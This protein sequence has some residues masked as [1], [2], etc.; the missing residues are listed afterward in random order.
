MKRLTALGAV[1][2]ISLVTIGQRAFE[3]NKEAIEPGTMK[4][5]LIPIADDQHQTQLPVT[6]FH[7]QHIGPVLG[8]TAGVHGYEYAPIMAGQELIRSID[9]QQLSGT[10]ILVQIAN[11]ESFLGRSPYVNPL[12]KKNLN[13]SFPGNAEGTVTERLADFITQQVI[14]RCN[15]FLD[16]HSGDAPEDLMP[17]SAYYQH[18]KFPTISHQAKLMAQSMGFDHIVVFKTT[19]KDYMKENQPSLYC[20]AQA[21]KMGIPSAD[22]ECGKLGLVEPD[23]IN[24]IVSAVQSLLKHLRMSD[25]VIE[26]N[27]DAL[28]IADRSYISSD[29]SGVFYPLKSSGDYITKGTKIGY[30]TDFF[31]RPLDEIYAPNDGIILYMLGT[32]PVNKGETLVTIGRVDQASE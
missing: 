12:D 1:M 14:P 26:L 28:L 6:V 17:Y 30:I 20:S 7:G 32:P 4:H 2:L 8:I 16:M 31:N 9:P 15:F 19:E 22:I 23:L 21:F 10:V 13:R 5:F 29:Q 27:T 3:F 11:L 25:G 24:K 18:H